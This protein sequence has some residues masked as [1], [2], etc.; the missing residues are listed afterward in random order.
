[1]PIRICQVDDLAPRLRGRRSFVQKLNEYI[2][3]KT[4]L[5]N[6]LKPFEAVEVTIPVSQEKGMKS[7]LQTFARTVKSDLKRLNLSDYVVEAYRSGNN[8]VIAVSN[9][10]PNTTPTPTKKKH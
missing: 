10:P 9:Q 7:I 2:E 3:L 6:G 8:N 1:M 5:S 4:K